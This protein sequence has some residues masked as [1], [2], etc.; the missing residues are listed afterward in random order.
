MI[1]ENSI[2]L[3]TIEQDLLSFF[4]QACTSHAFLLVMLF[5]FYYPILGKYL[6]CTSSQALYPTSLV[7]CCRQGLEQL[8]LQLM[9][10]QNRQQFTISIFMPFVYSSNDYMQFGVFIYLLLFSFAVVGKGSYRRDPQENL[11]CGLKGS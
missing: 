7:S 10:L 8:S 5:T 9:R 4:G 6:S 2:Q 11:A 3:I 1:L